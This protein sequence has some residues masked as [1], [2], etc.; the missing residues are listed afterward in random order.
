MSATETS[1]VQTV[2]DA[3][4]D[5]E[6]ADAKLVVNKTGA[7]M[8]IELNRPKVLN[9]FDAEMC[10]AMNR[11]IPIIARNP[12]IY[13]V[14]LTS[15]SPKAFCAGGDIKALNQIARQD[16]VTACGYFAD[17]YRMNWL[18][19]CFSK[20][21]VSL[22]DGMCMGSGAGLTSY[23]THRVAG[24]NY[25]WAM[26]ETAIGLFPDVGIAHVLARMPW[27]LGR[28]LGL[29]GTHV[30]ANDA[31]WLGLASH[32]VP[33]DRFPHIVEQLSDAQTVDPLLDGLHQKPGEGGIRKKRRMIEDYFSGPDMT[34]IFDALENAGGA[35]A[36]W[37]AE[38]LATLKKM[39][40]LSLAIAD[41]HIREARELDLRQVLTVDYRLAVRC[42]ADH[43]FAEGVR[44]MLIDKDKS[45]VWQPADIRDVTE[46]QVDAYFAPLGLRDAVPELDLA[47]RSAM[48]AQR[49]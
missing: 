15:N 46:E 12:D 24:D 3:G 39:S 45:P 8:Q 13:I 28:Y 34:S 27:P 2:R 9:A 16:M 1:A 14:I 32:I 30:F 5:A 49:V 42:L 11:E 33:S 26:P 25:R 10:R 4:P 47:S 43:D 23:N 19:E 22:I 36:D 6:H 17:E 40:P 41:R 20:P 21:T 44:A 31:H 48:Q 37:A 18:L 7:A 35:S 29:T 38:T